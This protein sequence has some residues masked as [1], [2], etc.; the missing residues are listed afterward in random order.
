MIAIFLWTQRNEYSLLYL[1][2]SFKLN[3]MQ[4]KWT[5]V[6]A[7][8]SES[9][10]CPLT[11]ASFNWCYLARQYKW[12]MPR[13][14]LLMDSS[15]LK[16][17]SYLCGS[18]SLEVAYS[19]LST[20]YLLLFPFFSFPPL[21]RSPF[22]LSFSLPVSSLSCLPLLVSTEIFKFVEHFRDTKIYRKS[23]S[24][25]YSSLKLNR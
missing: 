8:N 11:N 22:S 16:T 13:V 7:L 9:D 6:L 21:L 3:Y 25:L 14:N 10:L 24:R 12:E 19:S 2:P 17:C 5:V 20:I 23:R 4:L 1:Q 18:W 15:I